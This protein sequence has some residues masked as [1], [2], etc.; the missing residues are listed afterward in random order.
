VKCDCKLS[1]TGEVLDLPKGL[2][3]RFLAGLPPEELRNILSAARHRQLQDGRV[4]LRQGEPAEKMFIL[5]SGRA[6]HFVDSECGRKVLLHWL[7]AGQVFGG[8]TLLATP[9]HYVASTEMLSEGCALVWDR[10]TI[11]VAAIRVPILLDNALSIAVTEHIAWAISQ[12]ISLACNDARQRLAHFLISLAC[13][14]GHVVDNGVEL[15]VRNEDLASGANVTTFTASR[16]LNEWQRA[17]A[18]TKER[19]RILLRRP[20]ELLSIM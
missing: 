4:I 6:R 16:V 15:H 9:F 8:L 18:L 7:V 12:A 17:G 11:R 10:K 19:G 14:I 5:T 3:P 2:E 13:A 1:A 20:E